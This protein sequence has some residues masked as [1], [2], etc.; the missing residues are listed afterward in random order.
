MKGT[1]DL[2]SK[3]CDMDNLKKAHRNAKKGKGWYQ[4]VKQVEKNLDKALEKLQSS[5]MEHTYKT[6]DYEIFTKQEG[7]K[8]REIYKLPYYPDRICQWAILQVIEPYLLKTMTTDT[9]SAIP[10]RG[11]QPIIDQLRGYE[12]VVKKDDKVSKKWIPS[13]LISDPENTA[14]CLKLDVRKYYPTIV[15]DVLKKRYRE[16]FKDEDLIWLMDEIIDSISTCPATE[17]N[18]EVLEQ[19]GVLVNITVDSDSREFIDGVGIP[20]GNY[21]SQYD[22][23]FNLSPLD[24]WIK[25]VK[26]VKY[27][28]RY[29]DDMVIFGSSKEELH[30]LK[31]EIDEFMA[32]NLKQVLKHNWQVFPSKVRG[33]DF[34]GYRFFGEY[35]LLRKSTCKRLKKRMLSISYKRENNMS[36]TFSEWCSFNSYVGWLKQCDGYR[37]YQ[38]YVAPNVEYMHNY[39]LKEVK[40][41]AEICKCK[42]HSSRSAVA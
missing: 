3:I 17:E 15:H 21:V 6:S 32:D 20:I 18:I 2:F 7:K 24:H 14:Y 8:E 27:Y 41:N 37:L 33:I 42:E 40:G 35:T 31:K 11:I 22:G 36:P 28:F 30:K 26:G 25:E 5:L 9:Y 29:M 10:K 4:E 13:I 1:G 23:N 12:K 19:F 34:V 38:K 39:Y 16:L